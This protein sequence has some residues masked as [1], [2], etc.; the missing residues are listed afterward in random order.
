MDLN[1]RLFI[2]LIR[3]IGC[4]NM[5]SAF[6]SGLGQKTI[7][8]DHNPEKAR[9][10]A[11]AIGGTTSLSALEGSSPD[12]ILL[13]AVKPKDFDG[14][15]YKEFSGKLVISV[16]A[17]ITQ[18]CL[19]KSFSTPCLCAMPNLAVRYGFGIIALSEDPLLDKPFIENLLAPLGKLEWFHE[20]HFPAITALTGSG[21]AFV[22]RLLIS[23]EKTAE[24][25]GLPS[26]QA[27]PLAKE[28]MLT[29][30][31]W[32]EASKEPPAALI[33][34]VASKGGTTQAGLEAFDRFEVEKGL[35][36]TFIA[37]LNHFLK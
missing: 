23:I 4:G 19:K 22:L 16:M 15:L 34:K 10:L 17:G 6:V 31:Q 12:E 29:T 25:M 20:K 28:M 21:P 2:A 7:C 27:T 26:K 3:L 14:E 32:L 11:N 35:S 33:K 9:A 24:Q 8:Y 36:Q 13:L 1:G 30:L 37:A 5:G 18:E